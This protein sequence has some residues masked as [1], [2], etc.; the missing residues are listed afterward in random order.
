MAI[1][2]DAHFSDIYGELGDHHHRGI[3]TH[4]PD[5]TKPAL[6]RTM[7][8]QV[9]STRLFNEN[10]FALIAT[11]DDIAQ[12]GIKWV[13]VP[14]DFSDDGQPLHVKGISRLF[15]SYEKRYGMRFLAALGNHDPVRPFS[16]EAGKS[17]FLGGDGHPLAIFSKHHHR[18]TGKMASQTIC[19]D[20]LMNWGYKEILAEMGQFGFEPTESDLY[21]E[22]PFNKSQPYQYSKAKEFSKLSYRM[23]KQ[24]QTAQQCVDMPDT[25]YLVEPIKDIWVLSIDANVYLQRDPNDS[26]SKD[27]P[28]V[29]SSNA[30]YNALM[31]TKPFVLKWIKDVVSRAEQQGKTLIAF[32]HF[33]MTDFNDEAEQ[34]LTQLFGKTKVGLKRQPT[35]ETSRALADTGLKL[36]I[37]GHMHINDTGKAVG[38]TGNTLFNVQVP[39]LAAYVPAYKLMTVHSANQFEFETITVSSIARYNELFPHY[40]KEWQQLNRTNP[41][42]AWNHEMLD[43]KSYL[44]IQ[45]KAPGRTR[46]T[47]ACS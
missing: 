23:F 5:G 3:P 2:A 27:D 11:L 14:G 44:G 37:A 8:S 41:Q 18:C 43:V 38:K 9:R 15:E 1:I 26:R 12:K 21:F 36:H 17:D 47:K 20:E 34:E 30:G 4:T 6:I 19:S 46:P 25:S 31:K 40:E 7:A 28:F 16:I 13:L 29:G 39:T 33:P 10:Y 45:P 24:C 42:T 22:T 35:G 32:S